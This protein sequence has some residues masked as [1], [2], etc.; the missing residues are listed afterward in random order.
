MAKIGIVTVLYNSAPVLED[1][2]E[3]LNRQT[4]KDFSLYVVDNNSSDNSISEATRLSST[5]FF[6]CFFLPQPDNYG[7]AKGNNIGI[8]SALVDGC[9][10]VLLANNDIVL[11]NNTIELLYNGLLSEKAEMA[12]PKI[13]YWNSENI[14]WSV[15]GDFDLLRCTTT[16]DGIGKKDIG[17]FNCSR[18]IQYAPTCFMLI[19]SSIFKEY[20]L[21]D[22]KYFVYYDD[23]DFVW[24]T[25]R[26]AGVKLV[27]IPNSIVWHKVSFS[28]GGDL[29]RFTVYYMNRNRIYFARKNFSR[30]RRLV[31]YMFIF[32]HYILKD[33]F[34]YNKDYSLLLVKA[35][36][37]G[38]RM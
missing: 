10:F 7:V 23:T 24:R 34:D 19:K 28:T 8:D 37:D 16:D 31:F 29:S 21:M 33:V 12:V 3:S 17:Q 38:L 25:S 26:L 14:I 35:F 18:R 32:V 30:F 15:G 9:S 5:S 20:G 2:F 22:E 6:E 11:E 4:F 13:F 1:F 27:N 36:R